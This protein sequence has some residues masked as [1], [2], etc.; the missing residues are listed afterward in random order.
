MSEKTHS[1]DPI[2][3][4]CAQV[5]QSSLGP[6]RH[7]PG[8]RGQQCAPEVDARQFGSCGGAV[9]REDA[10]SGGAVRRGRLGVGPLRVPLSE[11]GVEA[12]PVLGAPRSAWAEPDG[13]CVLRLRMVSDV[14]VIGIIPVAGCAARRQKNE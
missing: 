4:A 13:H 5:W 8:R 1:Y 6:V 7:H 11:G 12:V 14:I 9:V 10:G 2:S 3:R